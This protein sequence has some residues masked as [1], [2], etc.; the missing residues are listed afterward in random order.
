M[1]LLLKIIKNGAAINQMVQNHPI[2]AKQEH[3]FE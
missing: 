1:V 3:R 2:K